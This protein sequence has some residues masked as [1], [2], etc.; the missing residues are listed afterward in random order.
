MTWAATA[1]VDFSELVEQ[2]AKAVVNISASTKAK[3]AKCSNSNKSRS[4]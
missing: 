4:V 1:V 2:N 3:K